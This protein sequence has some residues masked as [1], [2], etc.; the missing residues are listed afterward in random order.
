ME[1]RAPLLYRMA[2]LH[3]YDYV[4]HN[5]VSFTFVLEGTVPITKFV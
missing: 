4:I 2:V 1:Q 5:T 3:I